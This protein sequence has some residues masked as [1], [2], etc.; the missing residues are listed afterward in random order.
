MAQAEPWLVAA[1]V[2]AVLAFQHRSIL[3]FEQSLL[4]PCWPACCAYQLSRA[5]KRK[6]V[7]GW[8]SWAQ[9]SARFLQISALLGVC[10]CMLRF[11]W[12]DSPMDAAV[13]L[14]CAALLSLAQMTIPTPEMPLG[15]FV[16]W[17]SLTV[18]FCIGTFGGPELKAAAGL[19]MGRCDG[20]PL[21]WSAL[22]A[23]V[24]TVALVAWSRCWVQGAAKCA[25]SF[26]MF[27]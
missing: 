15:D 27:S 5:R 23:I 16:P 26:T 22:C 21:V 6:R 12:H 13:V 20:G 7:R 1:A 3:S 19:S 8:E 10:S 2:S 11:V 24:S 9:G 14:P 4:L 18:I 25:F 17:W